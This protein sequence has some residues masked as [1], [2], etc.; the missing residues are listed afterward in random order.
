MMVSACGGES[1][2]GA[3][4]NA[5]AGSANTSKPS[6]EKIQIKYWYAFGDKI[7]EAKQELVKRFNASQDQIEVVAEYQGNYDDL[8]AKVQAAFA[9]GDAPAVTDL[10]IASTGTFARYGMLQELAPFAEQDKDQLQ[11]DDFNPG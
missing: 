3:A 11:I 7:E 8:H 5:G 10:E 2:G 9:A 4:T 6:G 1:G